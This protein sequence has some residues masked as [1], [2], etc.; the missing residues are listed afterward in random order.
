M[1]ILPFVTVILRSSVH[2]PKKSYLNNISARRTINIMSTEAGVKSRQQPKWLAPS[3]KATPVLKFQN[4]LTKTKVRLKRR[5]RIDLMLILCIITR[6]ISFPKRVD[7]LLGTIVD[8]LYMMLLIWVM[9][10]HI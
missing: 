5:N 4:S 2:L 6:L 8:L 3:A 9:P 1:R 7:V 10:E